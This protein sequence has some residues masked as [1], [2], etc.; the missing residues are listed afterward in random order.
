MTASSRQIHDLPLYQ[1]LVH[2]LNPAAL[3]AVQN[4]KR[5]HDLS[6]LNER[7]DTA[8]Q[9]LSNTAA[10]ISDRYQHLSSQLERA[11]VKSIGK[12]EEI[13]GLADREKR[14]EGMREDVDDMT[15]RIEERV[16]AI[17]DAKASVDVKQKVLDGIGERLE[18][19][20]S[21]PTQSTLGASQSQFRR[22][23]RRAMLGDDG[24]DEEYADNETEVQG[25]VEGVVSLWKRKIG[26]EERSYELLSMRA[27]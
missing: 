25:A 19:G 7:L 5:T 4:L 14:L 1:P 26:E 6:Q 24:G 23:G 11:R 9:V 2:T 18:A 22:A 8:T 17:I 15:G 21:L 20:G 10:E 13:K 27:K 16:R 12:D 3:R